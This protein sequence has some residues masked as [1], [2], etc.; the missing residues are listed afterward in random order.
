[1]LENAIDFQF[2]QVNNVDEKKVDDKNK[3]I[4]MI[5]KMKDILLDVNAI[6]KKLE[7]GLNDDNFF[8]TKEN[9]FI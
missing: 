4:F 6:E 3:D 8:S 7:T 5:E 2:L 9:D 1:M